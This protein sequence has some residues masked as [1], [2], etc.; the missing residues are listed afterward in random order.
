MIV[1]PSKR[2]VIPAWIVK[3]VTWLC[4][5][6]VT[7]GVPFPSMSPSM[8]TFLVI[9]SVEPSRIVLAPPP[10]KTP[11]SKLIVSP[12]T[13]LARTERS[14]PAEPSSRLLVTVRTVETVPTVPLPP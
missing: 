10:V 14:E 3:S 4:P 2:A 8:V 13:A 5:S 9:A 12:A 6:T 7:S 11:G 1:S